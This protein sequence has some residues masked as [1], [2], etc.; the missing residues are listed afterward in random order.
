MCRAPDRWQTSGRYI[1]LTWYIHVEGVCWIRVIQ[2]RKDLVTADWGSVWKNVSA[3]KIPSKSKKMERNYRG[4]QFNSVLRHVPFWRWRGEK[5][6]IAAM[7]AQWLMI[8][9]HKVTVSGNLTFFRTKKQRSATGHVYLAVS[10]VGF[11]SHLV[12]WYIKHKGRRAFTF[13][14]TVST[15]QSELGCGQQWLSIIVDRQLVV[16]KFL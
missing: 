9:Q 2:E 15:N 13:V 14:L 12:K 5:L 4:R 1:N 3:S 6:V 11:W 16:M 10:S 7:I 8:K